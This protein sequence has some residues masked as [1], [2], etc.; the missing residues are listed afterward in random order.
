MFKIRNT[1]FGGRAYRRVGI[2]LLSVASL[3]GIAFAAR[4][5]QAEQDLEVCAQSLYVRESAGGVFIGTL[6]RGDH[7]HVHRYSPSGAWAYG[8][9]Y[10]GVNQWGWVQ[11]GWFCGQ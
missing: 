9:A 4:T 2:A 7:M 8:L 5:A 11:N 3:A 1:A 10:G 6:F